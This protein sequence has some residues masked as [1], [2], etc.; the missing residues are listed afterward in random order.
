M[1]KIIVAFL[2]ILVILN[3]ISPEPNCSY[4]NYMGSFTYQ[5]MNFKER[6]FRNC[7]SKFGLYKK[8]N[9][10]DTI[11]YRLCPKKIWQVW[12]YSR[13]IFSEKYKLPY[14]SWDRIQVR[15]GVVTN[16]TGYQDF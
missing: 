12:N 9:N 5:E 1:A 13:Y 16:K 6:N 14:V 15:R 4:S 10:S 11:L 3:F 2:I 7:Q 8:E